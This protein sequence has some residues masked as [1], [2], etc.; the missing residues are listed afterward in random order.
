M[1]PPSLLAVLITMQLVSSFHQRLQDQA[2]LDIAELYV[3]F[4]HA[5][6]FYVHDLP[7]RYPENSSNTTMSSNLVRSPWYRST[8]PAALR[9]SYAQSHPLQSKRPPKARKGGRGELM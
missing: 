3:P 4:F 8:S 7:G 1:W 9:N 2:A 6:W 5:T